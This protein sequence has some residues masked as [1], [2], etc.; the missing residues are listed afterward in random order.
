MPVEV[1]RPEARPALPNPQPI[2]THDFKWDVIVLVPGGD[3]NL[4]V[5]R[6]PQTDRPQP[7][8]AITPEAYEILSQN[9]AEILRWVKESNWRLKYYRGEGELDGNALP[10][11]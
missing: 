3:G 6:A 4:Q 11:Q 10:A 7:Y 2:E 9:M 5:Q 8:Y 1:A